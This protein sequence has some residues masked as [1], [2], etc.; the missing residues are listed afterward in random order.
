[1]KVILLQD[2]KNLGL[3]GDI[4]NVKNGFGRNFLLPKK[5]VI[6]ALPGNLK[7][8][9]KI[10]VKAEVV[11]QETLTHLKTLATNVSQTVLTFIRKADENGHLF[12]SVSDSDMAQEFAKME[13]DVHKANIKLEKHL[14]EV[15]E[16]EVTANFGYEITAAF[17]VVVKTE[18][19]EA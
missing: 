2:V 17:K 3:A 16:F 5:L 18:E 14:K 11:R 9:E 19:T 4:K 6:P 10:R 8:I 1:M 15:G 12:G 13:L 7:R